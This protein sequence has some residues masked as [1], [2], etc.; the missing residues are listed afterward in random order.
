[1]KR[2]QDGA[3]L[4]MGAWLI[5]SPLVLGFWN[6]IGV[7]SLDF[8]C[9]GAGIALLALYELRHR[10]MWGEWLSFVV[11]LWMVG[12]PW[13]LHFSFDRRAAADSVVAGALIGVLSVWVIFRYSPNPYERAAKR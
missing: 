8:Y 9:V 7:R 3:I 10:S 2:W 12:S 1:M 6:E 13:L 4:A 11:G 5:A